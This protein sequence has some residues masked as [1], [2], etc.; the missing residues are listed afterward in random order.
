MRHG[1]RCWGTGLVTL[2]LVL[3]GSTI[4]QAGQIVLKLGAE[5]NTTHKYYPTAVQFAKDVEEFTKGA[6]KI[7]LYFAAQ[8]G[9]A[10][11]LSE[12]LQM[13][14]IDLTVQASK[15]GKLERSYEV[16]DLPFLIPNTA[17]GRKILDGPIGQE[18][19]QGFAKKEARLLAYWELGFRHITN[20]RQPVVVP[21]DLKGMKIR[22]PDNKLRMTTF[23]TF[24]ASVA[25]TSLGELYLALKQGVLDGTE[26]PL[27][28]IWSNRFYEV[29]K[30]LSVSNHVF[31]P[32]YL[33][34]REESWK[35]L[36]KDLQTEIL[37]A[38]AKSRDMVRKLSDDED[39]NYVAKLRDAG[40]KVNEIDSKSFQAVG[41][42][43]WEKEGKRFGELPK[44][45]VAAQ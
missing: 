11:E 21:A 34:V 41:K 31:T 38:A 18:L 45:I 44:R 13:G 32:G 37:K 42:T 25:V 36:S 39:N 8:L 30:Y 12:G 1:I 27:G 26:Q 28:T 24:G 6:V 19:A 2:L 10:E 23:E 16:F 40:M 20:N 9:S 5:E 4:A 14:T 22:V 33:L 43:I 7:D 3:S 29:Q 15:I 35:K 17:T